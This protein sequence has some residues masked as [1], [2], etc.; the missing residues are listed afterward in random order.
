MDRKLEVKSIFFLIFIL[1]PNPN[2]KAKVTRVRRL[3]DIAN[4]LQVQTYLSC[5]PVEK[6]IGIVSN[7]STKSKKIR[8]S[9]TIVV[10][11]FFLL[12]KSE[13]FL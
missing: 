2:E 8:T 9:K 11:K 3:Y 10:E 13:A 7:F 1:G 4:I 6:C 5:M 12:F